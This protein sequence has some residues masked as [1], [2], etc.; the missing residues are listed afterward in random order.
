M[1]DPEQK[2]IVSLVLMAAFADGRNDPAER[3][4]VRRIAESLSQDGDINVSA[5]YQEVL[6][7]RASLDDA[8]AA[9]SSPEIRRLAYELCVGVCDA[10]GDTHPHTDA[11]R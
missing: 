11:D 4:E 6:L 8:A 9:L 1:T 10:D 3:A 2:S 5:I 7:K